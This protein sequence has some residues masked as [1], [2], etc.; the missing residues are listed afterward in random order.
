MRHK[1]KAR[2]F[3]RTTA[4]RTALFRNLVTALIKHGR[5]E[6]TL[7][8]AKE[9][10]GWADKMITLGKRGD[11]HARR[12]A[13]SVITEEKVVRRLFNE[14]APLEKD[15]PGGY[16]RIIKLGNRKGDAA[17]M[18]LVEL[19][20]ADKLS[21]RRAPEKKSAK[22]GKPSPKETKTAKGQK[23]EKKEKK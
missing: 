13:L 20:C 17:P 10:R 19:V 8:K 4:H 1:V 2:R 14:I 3:T 23:E 21:P 18:A 22:K 5:V 11:L 6:T 7:A 16:T 15:R 12:Q 9:L